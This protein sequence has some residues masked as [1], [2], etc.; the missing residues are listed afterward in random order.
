ML[1]AA[2]AFG[3][4]STNDI[5]AAERFYGESLGLDVERMGD[6]GMGEMMFVTHPDGG[7]TFIYEK[8]DHQPAT[9]TVLNFVVDDID[10]AAA[11]LREAGVT[12]EQLE[13]TGEDGI[14]RDPEGRMP[15]TLWFKD[16]AGN[17]IGVLDEPPEA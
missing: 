15:S 3:G 1:A 9:F 13:W 11:G 10:A 7:R 2:G 6:G 14:A 12:L 16:P 17:W 4:F 8:D 5:G